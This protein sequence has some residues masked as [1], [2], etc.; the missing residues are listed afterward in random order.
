MT[1][2]EAIEIMERMRKAFID[3]HTPAQRKK[4][5]NKDILKAY[6]MAIEAL[7]ERSADAE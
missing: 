2:K 5:E 3:L 1:D 6:D 7:R 4:K